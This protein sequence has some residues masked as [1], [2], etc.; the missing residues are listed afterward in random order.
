M[1]IY[2]YICIYI[3]ISICIYL[4]LYIYIKKNKKNISL[5]SYM[6]VPK[7]GEAPN[8]WFVMENPI[9]VDDL[10]VPLFQETPI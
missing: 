3:Y 7:N 6:G 5:Y 9:K 2:I 4:Y 8:G 10:G 1:Y